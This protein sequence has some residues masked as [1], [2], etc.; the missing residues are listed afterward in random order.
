MA[1]IVIAISVDLPLSVSAQERGGTDAAHP[2]VDSS[3]AT[4][5]GATVISGL[6]L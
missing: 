5:N 6:A 3:S 1:V 4:M 2:H